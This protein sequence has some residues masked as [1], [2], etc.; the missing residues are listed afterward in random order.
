MAGPK[1]VS[2]VTRFHF[3]GR[4]GKEGERTFAVRSMYVYDR[5]DPSRAPTLG[6]RT[7]AS[8]A[9]DL[10]VDACRARVDRVV[11]LENGAVLD[12]APDEIRLLEVRER[13][14]L[15]VDEERVW[16]DGVSD[17][18]V[19]YGRRR[20]CS[21]WGQLKLAHRMKDQGKAMYLRCPPPS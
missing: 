8:S 10:R 2:L 15:G 19:A 13:L 1:R 21:S 7:P 6:E 9:V 18:A 5:L 4:V 14:G 17:G 16:V 20:E 3:Y 12:R 11:A